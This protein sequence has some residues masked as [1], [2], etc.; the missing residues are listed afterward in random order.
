[1]ASEKKLIENV[2]GQTGDPVRQN[3]DVDRYFLSFWPINACFITKSMIV[4]QESIV[5]IFSI[6]KHKGPNSTL[7]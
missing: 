2:D 5:F 6:Q 3:F 7:P 1:M 4:P